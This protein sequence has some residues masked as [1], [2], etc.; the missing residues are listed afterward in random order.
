MQK[1][2]TIQVLFCTDKA[3]HGCD[4]IFLLKEY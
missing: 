1:E 2:I 4:K 3:R